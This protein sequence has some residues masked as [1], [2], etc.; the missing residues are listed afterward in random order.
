MDYYG[1]TILSPDRAVRYRITREKMLDILNVNEETIKEGLSVL[2]VVPFFEKFKLCLKVFDEIGKLIYKYIPDSPNKN[3]KRCY[4]QLKGNHI[5][6]MNN[7]LEKLRLKDV[8]DDELCLYTPSS[9]YYINEDA[10]PI[11]AKMITC[12]D[13]ITNIMK[14][15]TDEN[16][17]LIHNE[18]NLIKC[19]F[20]LIQSG[21][22][23]KIKFLG[24]RLTD[25]FCEFNKI[26]IRIQTQ[27]LIKG[28]FDGV[29]CVNNEEVYNSMNQ[30]MCN[31]NKSLFKVGHKSFYSEVDIQI[32]DEYRTV[33]NTGLF[34][35]IDDDT[36]QNLVE[37]DISKAY[38]YALSQI[39]E[40]PI[41][42]EFDNFEYYNNEPINELSLYIVKN[43]TYDAFFN[44]SYNLCYGK[45]LEQFQIVNVVAVKTPSFIKKVNYTDI[46]DTLYNTPISDNKYEDTFIKKQ[47]ANVNIGLLEKGTNKNV[48]SF[49][50][51]TQEEAEYYR[52]SFGGNLHLLQQIVEEKVSVE[53]PLNSGLE[54]KE[55]LVKTNNVSRV[56]CA[57]CLVEVDIYNTWNREK[58]IYCCNLCHNPLYAEKGEEKQQKVEEP[59]QTQ[60]K[61]VGNPYFVLNV[62]KKTTLQN[63]FRYIKELVLQHHNYKIFSDIKT[64]RDN[65]IDTYSVKTD[66]L[67]IHKNDVD[68]VQTLLSFSKDI[69]GWRVSKENHIKFPTDKL[70]LVKNHEVKIKA[71]ATQRLNV[72]DEYDNEEICK[73]FEQYKHVILRAEYGGSGK[74]YA[75]AYMRKL[76]YNV[77]FVSPTN[78]LCKELIKDYQIDC[79]TINKFFGFNA[80]GENKFMSKFDS[81]GY[82]CIIFDEIYFYNVSNLAKVLNYMKNNKDKIILATGDVDQL[83]AIDAVSNVKDYEEYINHCIN[84]I[85]PY[86]IF[87]QENKRLKTSEDKLMLKNLKYDILYTNMSVLAIINKYKLKTT[88]K[89]ITEDNIAYKNSR[90]V[91]VSKQV[92]KMLGKKNKY[93][94]GEKLV[95]RKYFKYHGVNINKNFQYIIDDVQVEYLI[96]RDE[97]TNETMKLKF[98]IVEERFIHYYCNTCHSRQ[99]STIKNPI[100]IHQ[101]DYKY[102]TRKWLYTAI[103]RATHFDNVYFMD[104]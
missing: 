17:T 44:K 100:T 59:S 38:T 16:I 75:C 43:N 89:I 102:F 57:S 94:V 98:E 49:L 81:S 22:H 50:F 70:C 85:F 34:V 88:D 79:I 21:Y 52:S 53:C 15:N 72:V 10:E 46:I 39:T 69:G 84:C 65:N 19:C 54:Q 92:R 73:L 68:K 12:I 63:G 27:H 103:T 97:N 101:W 47:I 37:I 83:E 11:Q 26:N 3:E 66:A 82:N 74:S 60:I 86:E 87:L 104:C 31:F 51:K 80:D 55:K 56:V 29:V 18:N 99:G 5:Y 7:N 40:I 93:E 2:Q 96:L 41:F 8:D 28:E 35:D 32:L 91:E 67:T 78:V 90:C 1:E 45:F 14:D 6:T 64:L 48:E 20:D 95:C 76:G 42:N 30:A 61:Q 58:Q 23:P 9:N 62:S 36:K 77:L 24:N 13:D 25:I 33:A 71:V 4:V